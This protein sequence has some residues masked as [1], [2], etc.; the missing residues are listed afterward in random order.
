MNPT[1]EVAALRAAL[2]ELVRAAAHLEPQVS[3]EFKADGSCLYSAWGSYARAVWAA[4]ALLDGGA[5]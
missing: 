3:P 4:K 5:Q 1:T 2:K